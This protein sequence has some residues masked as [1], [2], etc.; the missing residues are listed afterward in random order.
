[1]ERPG[2]IQSNWSVSP[3]QSALRPETLTRTQRYG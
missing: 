3:L 1:M 2:E